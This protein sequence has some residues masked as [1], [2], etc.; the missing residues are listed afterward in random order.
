MQR[1]RGVMDGA[2]RAPSAILVTVAT[3]VTSVTLLDGVAHAQTGGSADPGKG[4]AEVV[5]QSAFGN[6]TSQN[7]GAEFGYT[8]YPNVQVFAEI[9]HTRN[10]ATTEISTAAQIIAGYLTQAQPNA[11]GYTVRQPMTFGV[12]GAKFLLPISGGPRLLPY[13]MVGFGVAKISQD[14]TF[15]VAGTDVTANLAQYNI[16]LGGDLS[17]SF[18]KPL[19]LL[20]GGVSYP[21]WQSVLLDF[22]YRYGHVFV[23]G[24][25]I[26][27]SRAGIGLG[28]RF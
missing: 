17:G 9:G 2:R 7:Y 22:Q 3:L 24:Q 1:L 21:M 6:V 14:A 20:G 8:V 19:I 12:G 4:Y 23:P 18:T 5:A 13:A 15:S 10:V 28:L 26:N 27:V 16:V 25:T 11:V